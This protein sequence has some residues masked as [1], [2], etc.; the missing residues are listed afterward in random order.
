MHILDKNIKFKTT[1]IPSA[2]N[3]VADTF[4]REKFPGQDKIHVVAGLRFQIVVP[5]YQNL[6]KFWK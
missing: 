4:S 5:K 1:W 3:V 2:E 6:L